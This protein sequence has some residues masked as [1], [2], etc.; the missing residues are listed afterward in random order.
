MT[1]TGGDVSFCFQSE[2]ITGS[3]RD[4]S[5]LKLYKSTPLLGKMIKNTTEVVDLADSKCALVVP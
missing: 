1:L 4:S 3:E 5:S 2:S